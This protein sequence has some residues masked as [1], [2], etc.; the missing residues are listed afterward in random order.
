M[1]ETAGPEVTEPQ[2][3]RPGW[4]RRHRTPLIG[5]A[6]ALLLTAAV[7]LSWVGLDLRGDGQTDFSRIPMPPATAVVTRMTLVETVKVSG[8]LGYGEPTTVTGRT[9]GTITWLP[10]EGAIVERGGT[11]YRRDE[12]PVPLLYGTV[13]M[14][15]VLVSGAEGS[16]VRELEENLAALGYD[17]ARVLFDAMERSPNLGGVDLAAAIAATKDFKGVTG[18][19]TMD[20]NRDASKQAVML[21]IKGGKPTF[22]VGISPP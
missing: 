4:L 15:R 5:G 18:V 7:A 3:T 12:L 20:A 19:I 2:Q 16:D 13:P 14:Y 11:V 8:T 17:A 9:A 1:D 10:A 21:Q 6:V 22:V